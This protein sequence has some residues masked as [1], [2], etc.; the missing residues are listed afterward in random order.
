M[1]LD[2]QT[3]ISK[4]LTLLQ[5]V[6]AFSPSLSL[7]FSSRTY[8]LVTRRVVTVDSDGVLWRIHLR[9]C[10]SRAGRAHSDHG[11]KNEGEESDGR[12]SLLSVTCVGV[13]LR[14]GAQAQLRLWAPRSTW[15]PPWL[16]FRGTAGPSSF[17]RKFDETSK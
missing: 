16:L 4:H 14:Q 17:V 11:D 6:S 10:S 7:F 3:C 8:T 5:K 12:A 9:V 2:E 15:S 13:K 1:L